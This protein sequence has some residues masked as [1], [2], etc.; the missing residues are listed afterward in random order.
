MDM[1]A[2]I[3]KAVAATNEV[4]QGVD[5][6]QFADATPC[7]DFDVR[8]LTEHVTSF[9]PITIAAASKATPDAVEFDPQGFKARYAA[10]VPE[11]AAAWAAP[12]ALE[13]SAPFGPGEYPAQVA[14][15]ITLSEIVLHGWDLAKATGQS[16]VVDDDVAEA[17]HY[18]MTRGAEGGRQAGV[19]GPEVPVPD[20]ADAFTKALGLSGRDP[21]WSA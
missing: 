6:S 15:G 16:L 10:A 7:A 20:D 21:D 13:G 2:L 14:A 17:T 12:G 5:A 18:L 1:P 11:I 9:A 4:V 8:A 19:Y 3:A